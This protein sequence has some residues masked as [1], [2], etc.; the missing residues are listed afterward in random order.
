MKLFTQFPTIK[1]CF[2][3]FVI[4]C[5]SSFSLS[6]QIC[7]GT[8]V[9]P[10]DGQSDEV[11]VDITSEGF[12]D[13]LSFQLSMRFDPAL[14][15]FIG[16]DTAYMSS[17]KEG[18]FSVNAGNISGA[19]RMAWFDATAIKGATLDE[20]QILVTYRFK[21]LTS[22]EGLFVISND[23]LIIEVV[24][25]PFDLLNVQSCNTSES[26]VAFLDGS[27]ALDENDNCTIET[28]ER[29][30][31][32]ERNWQGWMLEAKQNGESH[33]ASLTESGQY[34]LRLFPGENEISVYR[35]SPY[36]S[37]CI[38]TFTINTNDLTLSSVVDIPIHIDELCPLLDVDYF[39]SYRNACEEA[40]S[41]IRY[42]NNGTISAENAYIELNLDPRLS[43]IESDLEYTEIA[44][45]HYRFDIGTV[46]AATRNSFLLR[47]T[48]DCDITAEETICNEVQIFPNELCGSLSEGWSG[49][50]LKVDGACVGEEI[51]FEIENVGNGDM[52]QPKEYVVIEDAVIFK[53]APIQLQMGEKKVVKVAAN[54]ATYRL[55][56]EQE[57]GHPGNSQ[58]SV[59]VEAC[60]RDENGNFST[61]F[62]QYFPNDDFDPFIDID[63]QQIGSTNNTAALRAFPLGYGTEHLIE[64]DD[65]IEYQI[66]Y[67]RNG[68]NST[69]IIDTL[70][71]MLDPTTFQPGTSS[72][73]YWHQIT[74]DGIIQ[75]NVMGT[76]FGN[77]FL[78]NGFVK[79]KIKPKKGLAKGS[80]I[81]NKVSVFQGL[82]A[83]KHTNSVFHTIGANF[84]QRS[85][86]THAPIKRLSELSVY[87]NPSSNHVFFRLKD[88]NP[89]NALLSIYDATGKMV[90]F[91]TFS[92]LTHEISKGELPTGI[93]T[94]QL[95]LSNGQ[96]ETGKLIWE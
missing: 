20:N 21:K 60:G 55:K 28:S 63:C 22:L 39:A 57:D 50:S 25:K 94:Y 89:N 66:F 8:E 54:G 33:Y 95:I 10:V 4:G 26:L 93:Y 43:I 71:D 30:N 52:T 27:F 44:A 23:P 41:F 56:V 19:I 49:A 15:E 37:T 83:P 73:P 11:L 9:R 87:P 18:N 3:F 40:L 5:L 12:T 2:L 79:F 91:E 1:K 72:S 84:I 32:K 82:K 76:E 48:V 47:T 64:G 17:F 16:M 7:F 46:E 88:V 70:S 75:F 35:P 59:F 36:Y 45:N 29:T 58:P 38:N 24:Q 69:V 53:M 78:Q 81:F 90:H 96:I 14:Y 42:Q 13:I 62:A 61:G 92:T 51:I 86:S 77:D 67:P 68:F 74:E 31:S 34:S 6:A 85:V 65:F 80:Q